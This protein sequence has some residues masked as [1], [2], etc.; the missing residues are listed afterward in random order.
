M[1]GY[2]AI[3][4]ALAKEG[5]K[6][7]F[8]VAGSDTVELL[9]ELR[10]NKKVTVISARKE[11]GAIAMADGYARATGTVGVSMVT[12]GPGLTNAGTA[13]TS[14][15]RYGSSVLCITTE[16]GVFDVGN[17]KWGLDQRLFAETTAG[18]YM[19]VRHPETLGEDIMMAFRHMR[20][21]GGPV[22]L[23]VPLDVMQGEFD[24]EWEYSA[25]VGRMPNP[26]RIYPDPEVVGR[27]A[28]VLR[29]AEKP[30]ILAGRGAFES[31]ADEEIRTLAER[32]GAIL[33]TTLLAKGY[34]SEHP[35]NVGIAG[36]FASEIVH[37]VLADAD[38]VVAVGCRLSINTTEFGL[39]FSSAQIIHI[40]RD[41]SRIGAIT[42][43]SVGIVGDARV[44][45]AALNREME[46]TNCTRKGCWRDNVQ[47]L[48][49]TSPTHTIPYAEAFGVVDPR[50]LLTEIDGAM[51]KERIVVAD[52]GHSMLFAVSNLSAAS[53]DRFMCTAADFGSVGLGLLMGIGAALGRPDQRVLVVTGDGGFMMT[54]QELD[55]AVR[56]RIPI[57]VVVMNDNGFGG[58][59]H[60]LEG[61]GKSGDIVFY[62]NPDFAEVARA[63]GAIGLTVRSAGDLPLVTAKMLEQ[64][65]PVLV[66]AKVNGGVVHEVL[67]EL[68]VHDLKR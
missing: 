3:A 36:P 34:L 27:A 2:E 19:K 44:T 49:A 65:R 33:A 58:E 41:A 60:F 43:V 64:G 37:S 28:N 23:A 11:D 17:P 12:I 54:L 59:A 68:H 53:P 5:V 1:R 63:L 7:V 42:P 4:D 47:S 18:K 35:H 67:K 51:P 25:P 39:L 55:T 45:V 66:D 52:G 40:D 56:Y 61:K 22:V 46:K 50:Q 48:I 15:R 26:Y 30:V 24:M 62:D 21:G 32:T 10:D 13:L 16:G 8:A 38:C 31:H 9:K 57:T 20:S 29:A 6:F 14:A